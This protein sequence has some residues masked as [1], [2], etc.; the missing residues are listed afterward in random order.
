[1]Y[2]FFE[3]RCKGSYFSY[4]VPNV[5][6][7]D[8]GE[9]VFFYR[10]PNGGCVLFDSLGPPWPVHP[11]FER[12]S[13][14]G[15]WTATNYFSLVNIPTKH[16]PHQS[17]DGWFPLHW[18]NIYTYAMNHRITLIKINPQHGNFTLFCDDLNKDLL[19]KGPIFINHVETI[20]FR[21]M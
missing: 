2:F 9:L 10:S 16:Q 5:R 4:T 17:T 15:S 7:W 21:R 3:V 20:L 8:C 6:C 12:N 18:Q 13:T 19:V 11:C 14:R 1:V